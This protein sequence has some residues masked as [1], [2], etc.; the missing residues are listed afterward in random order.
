MGQYTKSSSRKHGKNVG[1][2]CPCGTPSLFNLKIREGERI[3]ACRRAEYCRQNYGVQT[4]HPFGTNIHLQRRNP[5]VGTTK[6]R[7]QDMGR[8]QELFQ[9]RSSITAEIGHHYRKWGIYR[10][11]TKYLQCF[12]NPTRRAPQDNIKLKHYLSGNA[13][14]SVRSVR[15]GAIQ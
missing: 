10:G 1:V 4:D 14:A 15:T 13:D 8:V 6:P 11:G 9:P 5:R 3:C 12:T 7:P 2:I